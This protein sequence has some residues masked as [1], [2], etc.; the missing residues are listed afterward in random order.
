M[1]SQFLFKV[2]LIAGLPGALWV[3]REPLAALWMWFSD[4]EAVTASMNRFGI[5]GPVILAVLFILQ[6]FFAFIP[7]QALM[8]A[9]GFLY[10][11]GG[12]FLLSWLSLVAGGEMAFVLARRYG[13]AFVETWISPDVLARWDKTARGQGIGFFA[14]SLVLP[15]VPNDAMC[16]LAGL[17]KISHRR[18]SV[19][20]LL[21][22]G[23]ACLFTSAIGAFGGRIPWQ[24][25]AALVA[26]LCVAG[27]IWL[28]AGHRKSAFLTV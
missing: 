21:G 15:L 13:R 14:L 6:V 2:I 1:K 26:I 20:N 12:G 28:V 25:W 10:G 11:F 24:V 19:A 27:L 7:G 23:V 3:G 22:R 4:Q 5:W 17:G 16:Y 18:F 9:C 8:V